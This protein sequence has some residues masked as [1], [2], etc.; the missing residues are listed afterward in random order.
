[1]YHSRYCVGRQSG[2]ISEMGKNILPR[3]LRTGTYAY[4]ET[5]QEDQ[6]FSQSGLGCC[7]I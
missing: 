2:C 3:W 7:Q 6:E 4:G 1:L 5:A